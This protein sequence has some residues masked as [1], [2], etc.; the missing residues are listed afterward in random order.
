VHHLS[1]LLDIELLALSVNNRLDLLLLYWVD[2]L[3]DNDVLL[4]GLNDGGLCTDARA[5]SSLHVHAL[6]CRYHDFFDGQLIASASQ[7]SGGRGGGGCG[8]LSWQLV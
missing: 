4:D 8:S 2:S 6:L 1:H 3:V 7:R 5:L